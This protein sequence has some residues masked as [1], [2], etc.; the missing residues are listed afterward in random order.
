MKC[1]LVLVWCQLFRFSLPTTALYSI[2]F[3]FFLLLSSCQDVS[4]VL[5]LIS[6]LLFHTIW[7]FPSTGFFHI[8]WHILK[9]HMLM[10][11]NF[12][13]KNCQRHGW[14]HRL[15]YIS[16]I[17]K[18]CF[19]EA[20]HTLKAAKRKKIKL[21]ITAN[22]FLQL[23][24]IKQIEGTF[25]SSFSVSASSEMLWNEAVAKSRLNVPCLTTCRI[26]KAVLK[27]SLGISL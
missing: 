4:S 6:L 22:S 13:T 20:D 1:W 21:P 5:S 24:C 3:F 14:I 12:L 2:L 15:G 18:P 9:N 19:L 27:T 11:T 26:Q 10:K 16:E 25:N 17:L 23:T 8:S 7:Q